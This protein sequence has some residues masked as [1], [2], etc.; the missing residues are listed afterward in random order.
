M[1]LAGWRASTPVVD[2]PVCLQPAQ[3]IKGSWGAGGGG[4]SRGEEQGQGLCTHAV[5]TPTSAPQFS[6]LPLQRCS[7]LQLIK[8]EV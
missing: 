6:L 8:R 1:L 5:C 4:G 3:L 2:A 7:G